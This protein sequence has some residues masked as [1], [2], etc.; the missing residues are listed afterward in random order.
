MVGGQKWKNHYKSI[1]VPGNWIQRTLCILSESV[2]CLFL[3][4]STFSLPCL[5]IWISCID[6]S[7]ILTHSHLP[8]VYFPVSGYQ[9]SAQKYDQPI[10]REYKPVSG[11]LFK[12]FLFLRLMILN[13]SSHLHS[14]KERAYVGNLKILDTLIFLDSV[15]YR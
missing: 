4:N 10:L 9:E 5:E 13:Q 8:T 2:A 6:Y 11:G 15:L 1:Y 3:R 7:L 12:T 14:V